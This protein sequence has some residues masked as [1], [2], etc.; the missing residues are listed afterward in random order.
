VLPLC[1]APAALLLTPSEP[2]LAAAPAAAA[3]AAVA[4]VAVARHL[5][6]LP[7]PRPLAMR[8]LWLLP[9]QVNCRCSCLVLKGSW[10]QQV[11]LQAPSGAG[12]SSPPPLV[13][14]HGVCLVHSASTPS[15]H[16]RLAASKAHGTDTLKRWHCQ[17]LYSCCWVDARHCQPSEGGTWGQFNTRR[18]TRWWRSTYLVASQ[19]Q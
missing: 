4:A 11:D 14:Q 12:G 3:A 13:A 1:C 10:G 8:R 17:L 9:A 15:P 5:L 7:L 19:Q 6:Q 16:G 18:S 2:Q